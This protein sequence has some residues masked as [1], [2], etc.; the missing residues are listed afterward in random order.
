[1]EIQRTQG[2]ETYKRP[3]D[4]ISVA[5]ILLAAGKA[6]RM[7]EGGRHKLL[8]EFSGVPLVRHSA[9]QALQ[10]GAASVTVVTGHRQEEIAAVLSGLD[11]TI[12][13]NPNYAS[14]MASSLIAGFCADGPQRAKGVLVMLADM[15]R[16]TA[17][18]L[19]ALIE[20]FCKA[21]GQ[22]IIRA[23]SQGKRGNPVILPQILHDDV[24]Q[25]KG[26]VG[27]R[28][29]IESSGLAVIDIEIGDAAHLDVDTP[30]AVIAAGGILKR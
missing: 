14:G 19:K 22:A 11:V 17:D 26:D 9:E 24:M 13:E 18:D 21:D 28:N 7:G 6:S 3:S 2:R 23:V 4:G 15:P 30:E 25:L 27:A 12:A 5:I 20:A 16:V 1:M 8:A 10:S 29:I